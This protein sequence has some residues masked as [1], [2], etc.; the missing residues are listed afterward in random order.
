MGLFLLFSFFFSLFI[1]VCGPDIAGARVSIYRLDKSALIAVYVNRIVEAQ[2]G[3]NS[4]Q[5]YSLI[6]LPLLDIC[7]EIFTD[8]SLY[9][10][11]LRYTFG[12]Y[13]SRI[14]LN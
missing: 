9:N 8:I 2:Q 1:R 11:R 13:V 7:V 6:I 10:L 14:V 5:K 4:L 3:E 12:T